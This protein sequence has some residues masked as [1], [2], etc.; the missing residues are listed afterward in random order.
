MCG[1]KAAKKYKTDNWI[2]SGKKKKK[3]VHQLDGFSS[4]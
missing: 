2:F 3:K 1:M 4:F